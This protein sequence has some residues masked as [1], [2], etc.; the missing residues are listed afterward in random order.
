MAPRYVLARQNVGKN[1]LTRLTNLTIQQSDNISDTN[2]QQKHAAEPL[3][4]L[5][6]TARTY[7]YYS[8]K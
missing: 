8:N 5:Q 2:M 1:R 3:L 6:T 7:L 4:D